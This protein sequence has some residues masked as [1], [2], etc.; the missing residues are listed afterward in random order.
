MRST[1]EAQDSEPG[2]RTIRESQGRDRE[3]ATGREGPLSW[4][5][6][7]EKEYE[8]REGRD[9]IE[10]HE[11]KENLLT[12]FGKLF[13][14]NK[15]KEQAA[16][17]RRGV[18]ET[19]KSE[20]ESEKEEEEEEQGERPRPK[21]KKRKFVEIILTGQMKSKVS[22]PQTRGKTL[23]DAIIVPEEAEDGGEG[24]QYPL[25]QPS[26]QMPLIP[27]QGGGHIY[28]PFSLTDVG[29]MAAQMPPLSEGGA[30][31]M[32]AW[33]NI[34]SGQQLALGDF[35][36]ILA[37]QTSPF[38]LA[39]VETRAGTST[40]ID[41]TE[42]SSVLLSALGDVV[43]V[44][45]PTVHKT[46]AF[47]MKPDETCAAFLAR[48]EGEYRDTTGVHHGFDP[49]HR[50]LYKAAVWAALPKSVKDAMDDNP[51]TPHQTMIQ[52]NRAIMH[53][54]K[55][56]ADK[57]VSQASK[58]EELRFKLLQSQLAV[59]TRLETEGKDS[60]RSEK[61]QMPLQEP[62]IMAPLQPLPMPQ[63][64]PQNQSYPIGTGYAQAYP[65][66]PAPYGGNPGGYVPGTP[67]VQGGCHYCGI[68][69]HFIAA[70]R[71]RARDQ[72]QGTL[73]A[74]AH[75]RPQQGGY[76]GRG[77]PSRGVH[78]S[79]G[80][81]TRGGYGAPQG[82]PGGYYPGTQRPEAHSQS[83]GYPPNQPPPQQFPVFGEPGYNWYPEE[84]QYQT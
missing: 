30:P 80:G 62:Q 38:D 64:P 45:W 8:E 11:R 28:R 17:E 25:L 14:Q 72:E 56:T 35:R 40:F 4:E 66:P 76:R 20:S 73:H 42:L 37:S 23:R 1:T 31:W 48:A 15:K 22:P 9:V 34:G 54:H 39:E 78:P 36:R 81:P 47:A 18:R 26:A 51:E 7:Q 59:S 43:R 6:E 27:T 46:V 63:A 29:T 70:C 60:K 79:R 3:G 44:K 21:Q 12:E 65:P 82:G 41:R 49:T 58:M 61:K 16:R 55:K 33:T 68:A 67:G 32:R 5:T 77:A 75:P 57:V 53:F 83:Q 13:I 84:G 74:P 52:W 19:P 24:G 10:Q 69:G 50:S 71:S 2:A